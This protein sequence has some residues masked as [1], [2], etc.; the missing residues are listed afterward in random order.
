MSGL[1]K[2]YRWLWFAVFVLPAAIISL[3]MVW[4]SWQKY[5]AS[6]DPTR[7]LT[8]IEKK[9]RPVFADDL[10]LDSLKQALDRN[11]DFLAGRDPETIV[12]FGPESFTIRQMLESQRQLRRFIDKSVSVVELNHYLQVNFSVFE[13]GVAGF[14]RPGKI[15]VTGYYVPVLHGSRHQSSRFCQPLYKRP[16]DLVS[17]SLAEFSFWKRWQKRSILLRWLLNLGGQRALPGRVFGRLTADHKVVPYFNREEIDYDGALSGRQ[18][19]LVWLDD[20]IE[21]FFLHI[22]GT[23]RII[24]DEGGE[25]MVGYAAANGHPYRSIGAWLIRQGYMKREAVTM[26]AIR[27]FIQDHPQMAAKIFTANPSYIFFRELPNREPLGCWQIPL[28]AGRSIATDKS[29]FPAG[30]LA[31]LLTEIPEFSADGSILT[32][33]PSGRLVL[34]QDTGGAI[35]GSRRVDLFCGVGKKAEQMA[36]VMKQPGRLFFL[37]PRL[38]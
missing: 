10:S 35:K 17:I 29:L 33:Q 38:E 24:L 3:A 5:Q 6:S 9:S 30:G 28:T 34:N 2:R 7:A 21:R 20:N 37:A 8:L 16:D 22:Q 32:W 19:E 31:F 13:A 18:L 26:P 25:I 12:H 14:P 11:L 1:I 27:K 23:G 15:L 36:G 4:W